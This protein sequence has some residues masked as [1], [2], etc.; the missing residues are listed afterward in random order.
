MPSMP[1]FEPNDMLKDSKF[2]HC[3]SVLEHR[4][5]RILSDPVGESENAKV[6]C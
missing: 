4:V 3:W 5:L 1:E 6:G 2:R